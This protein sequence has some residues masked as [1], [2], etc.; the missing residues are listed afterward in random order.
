M[1]DGASDIGWDVLVGR[2]DSGGADLNS[3][4][5]G[6]TSEIGGDV[7]GGRSG[8]GGAVLNAVSPEG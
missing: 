4:R 2:S 7:I 6:G 3:V 1:L 5:L 8:S